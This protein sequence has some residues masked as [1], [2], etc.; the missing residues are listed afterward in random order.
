VAFLFITPTPN[1][2][3]PAPDYTTRSEDERKRL[4]PNV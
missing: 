4:V 1:P 3:I 2:A